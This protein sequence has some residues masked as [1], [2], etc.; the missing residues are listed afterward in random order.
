MS[1][2]GVRRAL[3][4]DPDLSP[5]SCGSFDG[6]WLFLKR[7]EDRQLSDAGF[8]V[9]S[10]VECGGRVQFFGS[11]LTRLIPTAEARG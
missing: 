9:K 4:Q 8:L 2:H 1:T 7:P 5:P 10:K 6:D 3:G 11:G